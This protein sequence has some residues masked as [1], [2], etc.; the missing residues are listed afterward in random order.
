MMYDIRYQD[1][2]QKSFTIRHKL[3]KVMAQLC[4]GL[5]IRKEGF[6]SVAT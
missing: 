2:V 1:K 6:R 3:S 5:D 4:L